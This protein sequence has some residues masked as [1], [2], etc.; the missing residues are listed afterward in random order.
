MLSA[1]NL[2]KK[3]TVCVRFDAVKFL[4]HCFTSTATMPES[5]S[6]IFFLKLPNF[7]WQI[8]LRQFNFANLAIVSE[9]III[10]VYRGFQNKIIIM[11]QRIVYNNYYVR[12]N[13]PIRV[14][15]IMDLRNTFK[16]G[17]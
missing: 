14:R 13:T 3:K 7:Y 10:E 5:K 9:K 16:N 6:N 15:I 1:K 8:S 4:S 12:A 11:T 17:Q 2:L